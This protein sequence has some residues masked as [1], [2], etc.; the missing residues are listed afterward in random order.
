[1]KTLAEFFRKKLTDPRANLWKWLYLVFKV[2]FSKPFKVYY[3]QFGEDIVLKQILKREIKNGFYVD[4]GCFHPIK[5]SNTLRL[6]L[7]GWRGINVDADPLKVQA[8]SLVRPGDINIAAAVSD[9]KGVARLY[10]FGLY[11]EGSTLDEATAQ[12]SGPRI[13]TVREVQTQTLT[14]II[15]QTKYAGRQIDVLSVDVEGHDLNVLKSLDFEIYSP[16]VIIVESH[17]RNFEQISRSEMYQF[18]SGKGYYFVSW[19]LFSM[20]FVLPHTDILRPGIPVDSD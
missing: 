14:E 15:G 19:V 10:G 16:K 13:Q 11:Q 20:F 18:I 12:K 7:R 3:S 2:F 4:V 1:M 5:F 6:Y 17:Y 8:F 9:E